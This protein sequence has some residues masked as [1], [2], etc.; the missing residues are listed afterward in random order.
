LVVERSQEQLR[1]ICFDQVLDLGRVL[2]DHVG[3]ERGIDSRQFE[4]VIQDAVEIRLEQNPDLT[5]GAVQ[6]G[7]DAVKGQAH[8]VG[9]GQ[10][11][12]DLQDDGPI[13]KRYPEFAINP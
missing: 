1:R 13:P 4:M 9:G 12:P 11:H 10:R 8:L 6:R 5:P 2:D 3:I 7:V